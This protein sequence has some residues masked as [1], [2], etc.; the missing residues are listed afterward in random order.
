MLY[1]RKTYRIRPERLEEFTHFFQT[2]LYPNQVEHGAKLVGRWVNEAA[3]EV[4]AIW[5]YTSREHYEQIEQRIKQT[6]LHQL[7][8]QKRQEAGELYLESRQD[9]LTSTIPVVPRPVLAVSGLITNQAGEV[10]LIRNVHRA[11]TFEMPGGRVEPGETLDEALHREIIE[12]TGI[13]VSLSGVTGVYQNASNGVICVVFRGEYE[14]GE[15][16]PAPGETSEVI[17]Q[18]LTPENIEQ[19][20]TRPHFRSRT[21][22]ALASHVFPY[23]AYRVKPYELLSRYEPKAEMD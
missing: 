13:S 6:R 5:E 15:P 20:I 9:F 1:R 19:W 23:E 12:E 14:S 4:T 11:D 7:A 18:K 17:F 2:Y 10:L 3:D 8:Q 22:D 21:L 16:R